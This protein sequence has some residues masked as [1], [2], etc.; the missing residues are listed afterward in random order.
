MSA[1]SWNAIRQKGNAM[2]RYI[3]ADAL[4]DA[5][6]HLAQVCFGQGQ[7]YC[8]RTK[9][10]QL[11]KKQPTVDAVQVVRCKDCQWFDANGDYYDS[12]CDKNGISVEDDFYCAD[13]ERRTDDKDNH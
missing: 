4:M 13:G 8:E 1:R 9:F 10:Q 7:C 11:I 6:E 12:Y 5:T 2:S 3:D